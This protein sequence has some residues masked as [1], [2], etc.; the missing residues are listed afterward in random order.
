MID[1]AGDRGG[2]RM[3]ARSTGSSLSAI[4]GRPS[5][6]RLIQRIFTGSS[7]TG[8]ASTEARTMTQIS[9]ELVASR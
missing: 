8:R 9:P 6:T 5:V 7:G 3:A 2:R 4:A 1:S